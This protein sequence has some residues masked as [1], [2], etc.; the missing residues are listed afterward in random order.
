MIK[1]ITET[2]FENNTYWVEYCTHDYTSYE[3]VENNDIEYCTKLIS[4]K[5]INN[6]I[7]IISCNPLVANLVNECLSSDNEMLYIE[8]DE[9][10]NEKLDIIIEEVIKLNLSDLITFDENDC[11]ITVYGEILTRFFFRT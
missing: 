8:Y 3:I 9:I 4:S 11:A 6:K 10:T 2:T 1:K 7:N 5:S